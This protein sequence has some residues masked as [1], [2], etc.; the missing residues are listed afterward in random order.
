M[1]LRLANCRPIL[2]RLLPRS[3]FMPAAFAAADRDDAQSR[4]II[5]ERS[6]RLRFDAE[7]GRL[8]LLRRLPAKGL[9]AHQHPDQLDLT[10]AGPPC[11]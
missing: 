3:T 11:S 1:R 2:P 9:P 5:A 10:Q 6:L 4:A 8:A 7:R